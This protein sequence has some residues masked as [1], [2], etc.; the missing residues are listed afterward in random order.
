M[1]L[2]SMYEKIMGP[3]SRMSIYNRRAWDVF[4]PILISRPKSCILPRHLQNLPAH[5]FPP[6]LFHPHS[7][8]LP[9]KKK[10]EKERGEGKKFKFS[11]II[12]ILAGKWNGT[13][14]DGN[15]PRTILVMKPFRRIVI[16]ICLF[17]SKLI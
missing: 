1:C 15:S 3:K 9:T 13:K 16:R 8:L 2:K 14:Y 10:I 12:R 11:N 4:P 6:L 17:F 7:F 5:L